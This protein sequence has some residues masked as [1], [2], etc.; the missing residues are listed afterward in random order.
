[1]IEPYY[2]ESPD[3]EPNDTPEDAFETYVPTIL[4]GTI[5]KPG[6]V[7]YYK[8]PLTRARS[9]SSP[10]M[11]RDA[12]IGASADRVGIYDADQ[13]LL[14]EFGEDGGTDTKGFPGSSIRPGPT[15]CGFRDYRRAEARATST[16]SSW[17]DS[18][19]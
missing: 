5:S 1:M 17:A 3:R 16:A 9:W 13:N 11:P 6:D 18:R 19:W 10:I 15:T 7:D 2:G 14:K 12:G 4:V 8:I